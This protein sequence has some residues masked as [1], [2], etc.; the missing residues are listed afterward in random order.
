[1]ESLSHLSFFLV[2]LAVLGVDGLGA[3]GD[4]THLEVSG[5]LDGPDGHCHELVDGVVVVGPVGLGAGAGAVGVVFLGFKMTLLGQ[6]S[7]KFAGIFALYFG[8]VGVTGEFI[9]AFL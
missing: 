3:F 5:D 1:M 8:V 4:F 2:V 7:F 9:V 6:L